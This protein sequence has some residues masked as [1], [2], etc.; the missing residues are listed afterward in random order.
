MN[1]VKERSTYLS[2]V[3]RHASFVSFFEAGMVNC[4][5]Q[6]SHSQKSVEDHTIKFLSDLNH[7]W[8]RHM[9]GKIETD[10]FYNQPLYGQQPLSVLF[11]DL[12]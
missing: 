3:R 9:G 1:K 10:E 11:E 8:E 12:F 4:C 5:E 6:H 2:I 7:V